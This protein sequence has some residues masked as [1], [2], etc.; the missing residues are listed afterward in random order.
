MIERIE[1]LKLFRWYGREAYYEM[2]REKSLAFHIPEQNKMQEPNEKRDFILTFYELLCETI[3]F[4]LN[5]V[6]Y[7]LELQNNPL[8]L[9]FQYNLKVKRW[10]P[11]KNIR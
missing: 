4:Q 9:L 7:V 3:L 8:D 5:L 11:N 6:A 1:Q 10:F 2:E